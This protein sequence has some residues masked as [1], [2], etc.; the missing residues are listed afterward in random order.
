MSATLSSDLPMLSTEVPVD[1]FW[2]RLCAGELWGD[3]Q[4]EYFPEG[5]P[6]EAKP[7]IPWTVKEEALYKYDVPD[8]SLRKTIW[9]TFPVN[10]YPIRERFADGADR[11]T[12]VWNEE[13]AEH[14][15]NFPIADMCQDHYEDFDTWQ[16]IRLFHALAAHPHKYRVEPARH[17]GEMCVIAMVFTPKES[18]AVAPATTATGATATVSEQVVPKER[19]LSVLMRFPVSWQKDG[20]RHS[21][22]IHRK[23]MSDHIPN[24][25]RL[26]LD[27]QRFHVEPVRRELLAA[28]ALC[29]DCVVLPS[30]SEYLCVVQIR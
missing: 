18:V 14:F 27:Q 28:L 1:D 25:M 10:V 4:W 12:I 11:Y 9:E 21:V 3:L 5:L 6:Q 24:F 8:L 29:D 30:S 7:Y 20:T 17:E 16:S 22:E 19:A 26:S 15:K 2:L 23:K 13:Q